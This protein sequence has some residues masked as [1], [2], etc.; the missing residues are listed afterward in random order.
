M[1]IIFLLIRL[2]SR[3]Q[4]FLKA[5]CPPQDCSYLGCKRG[6]DIGHHAEKKELQMVLGDKISVLLP[7]CPLSLYLYKPCIPQ[8]KLWDWPI[9]QDKIENKNLK[10]V[11]FSK[12]MALG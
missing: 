6:H 2:G 7:I 3:E 12:G 4:N 8:T 11:F 1:N 5:K 9:D 10:R